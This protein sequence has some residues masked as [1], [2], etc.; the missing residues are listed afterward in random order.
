MAM[1]NLG[2]APAAHLYPNVTYQILGPNSWSNTSKVSYAWSFQSHHTTLI[3]PVLKIINCCPSSKVAPNR[4]KRPPVNRLRCTLT[5]LVKSN[6]A[7]RPHE[8]V[9][10][11]CK[12][13]VFLANTFMSHL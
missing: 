1:A 4:F 2:V 7:R 13:S 8:D 3:L 11:G 9:H 10:R 6:A 12:F 5:V